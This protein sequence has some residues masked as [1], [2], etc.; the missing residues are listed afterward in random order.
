MG[1]DARRNSWAPS[2]RSADPAQAV[3]ALDTLDRLSARHAAAL[4]QVRKAVDRIKG[5]LDPLMAKVR[6]DAGGLGEWTRAAATN[7]TRA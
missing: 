4:P 7:W 3:R 2:I 1:G 6:G 5:H